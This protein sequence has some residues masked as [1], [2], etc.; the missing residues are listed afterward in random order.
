[1]LS[2]E[3]CINQ[4]KHFNARCDSFS[5]IPSLP[6]PFPFSSAPLFSTP[7]TP[8]VEAGSGV[9]SPRKLL[10]FY[11]VVGELRRILGYVK[12]LSTPVSL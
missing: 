2:P 8:A 7:Y 3:I 10:K 11:I 1:M 6:F 5:P 4:T 9:L 12:N